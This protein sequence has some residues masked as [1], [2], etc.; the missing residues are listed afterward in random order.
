[1]AIQQYLGKNPFDKNDP[2]FSQGRLGDGGSH[3]VRLAIIAIVG[4]SLF[5]LRACKGFT[6]MCI[7]ELFQSRACNYPHRFLSPGR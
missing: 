3:W 1:M 6:E 5:D 4:T 2:F 7:V